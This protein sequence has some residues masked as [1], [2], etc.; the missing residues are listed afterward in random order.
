[1][2]DF[3]IFTDG[4]ALQNKKN[5]YAGSAIFVPSKKFLWSVSLY[6]TNNQAELNA[7][8]MALYYILKNY[9][10][11]QIKDNNI[12]IVSDSEYS[13]N[14]VFN[15]FKYNVNRRMIDK[16][17]QQ[18]VDIVSLGYTVIPIHVDAHT[19]NTDFMSLNND[20]VDKAA[21]KKA[22]EIKAS[23]Q[24]KLVYKPV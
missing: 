3:Y 17:K 15:N 24:T 5:A 10:E 4:S 18:C 16:C 13:I 7:I 1:M 11:L 19:G 6:G 20:I 22:N 21:R 2:E 8:S 12:Y 23:I 9:S 14:V